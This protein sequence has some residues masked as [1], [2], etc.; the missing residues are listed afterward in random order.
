MRNLF[1]AG[2]ILLLPAVS[3]LAQTNP[4]VSPYRAFVKTQH[5]SAKEYLLGLFDRHDV[6]IICERFHGEL[7]QYDLLGE[8]IADRRFY[9]RVGDVFM[10]IGLSSLQDSMDALMTA[11][12]LD[13]VTLQARLMYLQRHCSMWPLWANA[14]YF[15]FLKKV[16]AVNQSLPLNQG[17]RI[18]P[19]D[20][21]FS[22]EHADSAAM[23]QLRQMM[24]IRDSLIAG[25]VITGWDQVRKGT[26]TRKKILVILNYRHAFNRGFPIPGS[27]RILH[28]SA[29]WI[30][31]HDSSRVA[32]VLL[33]TIGL[34]NQE[35]PYLIQEG[36]WDAAMKGVGKQGMGFNFPGSPFGKDSLDIWTMPSP[37]HYQD[38]FSGY[39]YYRPFEEHRTME[40]IRGYIDPLFREEVVRR[41]Q[42]IGIVNREFGS[43]MEAMKRAIEG[44]TPYLNIPEP[45]PY[46][47]LDQLK[48]QRARWEH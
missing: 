23:L 42:L 14:N 36:R 43:K 34:D 25:Q 13:T 37:F 16:Y 35:S 1:L 11:R 15:N 7:T 8:L 20:V 46:F 19:S 3:V 9:S 28:N 30:F 27:S 41:I 32:N 17:I 39:V 44:D 47:G 12:H 29:Y 4:G 38:V 18:H 33:N 6:V 26:G 22:W 45:R 48:S 2:V 24:G 5:Q 31:Q 40:G 10:E 21:P